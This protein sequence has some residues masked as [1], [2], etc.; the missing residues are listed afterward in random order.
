KANHKFAIWVIKKSAATLKKLDY[1]DNGS[2]GLK[3][4]MLNDDG[5]VVVYPKL[6]DMRVFDSSDAKSELTTDKSLVP[7]PA[8]HHLS[9][10]SSCAFKDNTLFRGS[11]DSLISLDIGLHRRF[12]DIF[13]KYKVFSQ[14]A[15][16]NIIHVT[17]R[18]DNK[19][20]LTLPSDEF[21]EAAFGLVSPST[22]SIKLIGDVSYQ[23]IASAIPACPYL[24]NIQILFLVIDE[25]SL[26]EILGI[27]K[28][29]PLVTDFGCS[30]WGIDSELAEIQDKLIPTVAYTTGIPND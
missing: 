1:G 22:Q 17:A 9:V 3:D 12:V 13:R 30:F 27:L 4:F 5:Q 24:E 16:P 19:H 25:M 6:R 10:N 7:F 11:S 29:F 15:Y 8:L 23:H 20:G 14:G 2:R 28:Y 26:L 18:L 21:A